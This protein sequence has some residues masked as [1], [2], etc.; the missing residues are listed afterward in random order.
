MSCLHDGCNQT[1]NK[2]RQ[3]LMITSQRISSPSLSHPK[4][5]SPIFPLSQYS[6][7]YYHTLLIFGGK[8]CPMFYF[9]LYCLAASTGLNLRK[10][11]YFSSAAWLFCSSNTR[12]LVVCFMLQTQKLLF[13]ER[14]TDCRKWPKATQRL[15]YKLIQPKT[16]P[17]S[18]WSFLKMEN[19]LVVLKF[20]ATE[21]PYYF[22]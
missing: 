21:I 12:S 18:M 19:G 1:Q 2:F 4:H 9:G 17:G 5:C 20:Q 22:I 13:I 6:S 15:K 8:L 11:K 3:F 14:G 10:I 7:Y 16:L